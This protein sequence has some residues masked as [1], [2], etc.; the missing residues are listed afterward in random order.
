ME[1]RTGQRLYLAIEW[2][3]GGSRLEASAHLTYRAISTLIVLG[4]AISFLGSVTF[5]T[6]LS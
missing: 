6:P 3:L 5:N 4:R 1:K 2:G